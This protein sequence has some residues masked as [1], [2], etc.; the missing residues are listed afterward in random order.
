VQTGGTLFEC[1]KVL[2]AEGAA[3]VSA[4]CTH[5]VFPNNSFQ[6]FSKGAMDF[7]FTIPP[8]P[9]TT[10]CAT[11]IYFLPLHLPGGDRAIFDKFF[12]SNSNPQVVSKL[13]GDD[14]FEV[15]DIM[16]LI[17]NDL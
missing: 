13:P 11:E 5:A 8:P 4:F 14:C 1:G 10:T 15:L 7:H 12:V 6:R 3:S 16:P 17:I 2:K 9:T